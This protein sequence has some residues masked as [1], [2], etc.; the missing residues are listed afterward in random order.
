MSAELL[1]LSTVILPDSGDIQ[2]VTYVRNSGT[3]E[4]TRFE[5][6]YAT[7]DAYERACA[8]FGVPAVVGDLR[9]TTGRPDSRM[10]WSDPKKGADGPSLVHV[11]WKHMP[12]WTNEGSK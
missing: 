8:S 11:C 5:V 2:S 3:G 4:V 9:M 12:C 1:P 10:R 7:C 6:H